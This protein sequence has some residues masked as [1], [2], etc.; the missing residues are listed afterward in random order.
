MGFY[1][2]IEKLKKL[3]IGYSFC[4]PSNDDYPNGE[5]YIN[6]AILNNSNKEDAEL[7]LIACETKAE[8]ILLDREIRKEIELEKLKEIK[9]IKETISLINDSDKPAWEKKILKVLIRNLRD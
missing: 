3:D 2:R 8:S 1:S 6:K 4:P 5:S 7:N 9:N